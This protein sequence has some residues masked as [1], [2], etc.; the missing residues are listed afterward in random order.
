MTETWQFL[1]QEV[2]NNII[3]L[4]QVVYKEKRKDVRETFKR[5]V[6]AFL[7]SSIHFLSQREVFRD[8]IRKLPEFASDW[9]MALTSSMGS[10]KMPK[11]SSDKCAKCRKSS[12]KSINLAKWIK[13]QQAEMFCQ[14]CFSLPRL[15]DWTGESSKSA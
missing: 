13:E 12:S 7:L 2:I 3:H 1:T 14:N 11:R 6:L 4:V 15:E 5:P 9:A 8:L 10:T